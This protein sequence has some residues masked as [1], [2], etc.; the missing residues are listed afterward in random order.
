MGGAIAGG[1]HGDVVARSGAA[2]LAQVALKLRAIGAADG[3]WGVARRVFVVLVQFLVAEI[4]GVD[5]LPGG[6]GARGA[7]NA[8]TV[9]VDGLAGGDIADGDFMAGGDVVG[10][11][12][13]R[14]VELEF[15]SG[16]DGNPGHGDIIGPMHP[17]GRVL[18][19]RQFLDIE[20]H[21]RP[22]WHQSSH[23]PR[24]G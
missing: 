5:V 16:C 4:V 3:Q 10:G 9:S 23:R 13:A 14:A 20:E 17:D 2:V 1:D 22:F 19:G 7:P 6:D 8:V 15:G 18:R 24:A 21:L 11:D 12:D